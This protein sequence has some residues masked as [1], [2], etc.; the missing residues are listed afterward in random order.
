M[1]ETELKPL[2]MVTEIKALFEF[3]KTEL[4]AIAAALPFDLLPSEVVTGKTI[5]VSLFEL[6]KLHQLTQGEEFTWQCFLESAT[7]TV[8][9]EELTLFRLKAAAVTLILLFRHD[10]AWTVAKTMQLGT[11]QIDDL[12][13]FFIGERTHWQTATI[14]SE[15]ETETEATTA[16]K[17]L[18]TSGRKSS[19]DS[20]TTSPVTKNLETTALAVAV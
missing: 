2:G 7:R 9:W 5:T 8:A 20:L 3:F 6:P 18:K 1:S 17:P 11:Q 19:G 15:M 13:N 16:K 14:T 12:Y 4:P 10:A